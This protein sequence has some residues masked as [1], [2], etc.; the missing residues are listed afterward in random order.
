MPEADFQEGY[1]GVKAGGVSIAVSYS[2]TLHDANG[3]C[4]FNDVDLRRMK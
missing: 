4:L 1:P 2:L 3:A